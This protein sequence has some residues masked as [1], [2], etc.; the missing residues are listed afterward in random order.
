MELA[1]RTILEDGFRALLS[2]L[3]PLI[4]LKKENLFFVSQL[5]MH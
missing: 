3:V 4:Y 1:L 5:E 2:C